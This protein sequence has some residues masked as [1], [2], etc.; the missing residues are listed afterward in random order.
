MKNTQ[1]GITNFLHD[2]TS[3]QVQSEIQQ[4]TTQ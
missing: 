4:R 3:L 2:N 1:N